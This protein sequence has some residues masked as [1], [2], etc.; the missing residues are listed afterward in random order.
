MPMKPTGEIRADMILIPAKSEYVYK[1]NEDARG[2]IMIFPP[3]KK[4]KRKNK[5]PPVATLEPPTERSHVAR[6]L[7]E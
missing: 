2:R 5:E 7:W 4:K 1:A 6:P 3:N